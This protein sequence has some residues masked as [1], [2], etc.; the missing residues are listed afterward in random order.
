VENC[1]HFDGSEMDLLKDTGAPTISPK[2]KNKL[3]IVTT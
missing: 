1:T 3:S 2:N